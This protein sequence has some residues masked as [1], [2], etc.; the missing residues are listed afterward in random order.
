[1]VVKIIN[2]MRIPSRHT[3]RRRRMSS[4]G[5]SAAARLLSRVQ[6]VTVQS[7]RPQN[8]SSHRRQ[9]QGA[10]GAREQPAKAQS[11]QGPKIDH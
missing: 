1:M 6:L 7:R 3:P 5:V 4:T 10:P 9:S 11:G 2:G 8:S